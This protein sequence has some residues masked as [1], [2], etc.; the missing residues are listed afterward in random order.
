M[1]RDFNKGWTVWKVGDETNKS[2]VNL[3]HDA[4]LDEPR[5]ENGKG[6]VNT[7]WHE[8]GDYEYEKHFSIPKLYEKQI[9]Y[10]EFEGVYRKARV[11]FNGKEAAFHEYGYTGFYVKLDKE[12]WQENNVIRVTAHNS[13]LPNSRWYSGTGIYRPVFLHILPERHILPDELRIT[14]LDAEQRLVRFTAETNDSGTVSFAVMDKDK[15][16]WEG[17]VHSDGIAQTDIKLPEAQLWAPD[18]PKLYQLVAAFEGDRQI[19]DFGIRTL[20]VSAGKGFCINGKR[21]LLRGACIHHDNGILGACAYDGAEKR[22]IRILK[23]AGYN[24][25]RSA[26]NPCSRALLEACDREGMLVMDEYVDMWYIHKTRNDYANKVEENYKEDLKAIV[27][28]DYNHPSV[29]MYST[30]NEVAETGED[31]GIALC[32]DMTQYLH[33]L[34]PTRPVTCGINIFF[35]YMYALGF[36]VYTE[37]KAQK[38]PDREVGSAFFNKLA[39]IFG[40]SSMKFGATLHGSDVK[41]RKAFQEMDVAGYNYGIW[42]YK[43]DVRKYPERVIVGSETFC[44]DAWLFWKLANQYPAIIGDFVW[45]GMDYLGEVGIGSWDYKDDVVDFSHGPGWVSAGSGRIDLIGDP[46]AEMAYTRVAFGLETVELGVAPVNHTKHEHAPSSW[47]LTNALQSWSWN[48]CEGQ[49]AKVEV[50]ARAERAE[51]FLNGKKIGSKK[52]PR[53]LRTKFMI[54]YEP[55]TLEVRAY[56]A[57]G[58]LTGKKCLV[59][60][61]EDT[62]LSMMVEEDTED[63]YF[64]KLR[65][66]DRQ[67]IVKP[68]AKGRIK[69]TVSGGELLGMGSACPY[70]PSGFLTDETDTYY[71]SAMAVIRPLGAGEITIKAESPYGIAEQTLCGVT[72]KS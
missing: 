4:M 10:V 68:L 12:L 2:G 37:E 50:Y 19:R 24:A 25:I 15:L 23:E 42:R 60:A 28:K 16:L 40:S 58:R 11:V 32:R 7:G 51:L 69:M 18:H 55:G 13:D 44:A 8:G 27:Q 52:I 9:V 48:G 72:D 61:G 47:K 63:L 6:G 57:S 70:N 45:A 67:G 29:I 64:V 26:H 41:T 34:D 65:Y 62:R 71:G 3:P 36:G 21:V 56:D 30:G 39:T 49:K 1:K 53:T 22:K 17:S 54:P 14:T 35:N 66:T 33:S 5:T 31:R 20:E 46:L 38:E 59:S 43:K